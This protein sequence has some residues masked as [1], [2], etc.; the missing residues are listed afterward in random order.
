LALR[1]LREVLPK[2]FNGSE[3]KVLPRLLKRF[4]WEE[5]AGALRDFLDQQKPQDHLARLH[6]V[7]AVCEPVCRV[8]PPAGPSRAALANAL[9]RVIE[10]WDAVPASAWY[11][12]DEKRASVVEQGF[13]SFAALSP[14]DHL[15]AF[16]RHVLTDARH[17]GLREAIIPAVQAIFGWVAEIAVAQPAANRILEHCLTELR[18]ATA[19]PVLPPKDWQRDAALAC[20]CADCRALAEFL[21]DPERHEGRF[22]LRKERRQ[23]LH[24][25]IDQHGLD[26]THV[27]DRRGSPQTLVCTKTQA[28]FERR[29]EQYE[30]DKKLLKQLE[31]FVGG[32]KHATA[33]ESPERRKSKA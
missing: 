3:G 31:A 16:V 28:S 7:V 26:C 25:Q 10:R 30:S 4:G 19:Q 21:R 11:R 18:D 20:K 6:A 33:K 17:Y 27:T 5:L 12:Q 8:S 24:R 2:D 23:H 14:R 13:R 32:K 29:Q 22:P 9:A 15:D 1:F